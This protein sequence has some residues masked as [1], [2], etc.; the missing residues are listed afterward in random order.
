MSTILTG[1][2][3]SKT[4]VSISP[5]KQFVERNQRFTVNI[6][7]EPD[8][9]ISGAQFDF[10]FNNSLANIE[11]V[12][13]GDMLSQASAKTY[14]HKGTVDS[15]A[16]LI[17]HIFGSVLGNS[18][19]SSPGIFATINLTA[20]SNTG[21]AKFNLSNVIISGT[22][23]KLVSSITKNASVLIDTAP[24]LGLI[25]PKSVNEINS[26]N[27]KVNASD[28]DGNS[29]TFSASGLP[30]GAT[31]NR[32]TRVFTWVPSRGQTGSYTVTFKVSDG[33]LTDSEGVKITVKKLNNAPVIT[34]F[35]PANGSTFIKGQK[36]N[37]SLKAFD[38]D[39]QVLSYTIKIDGKVYTASS[40]YVWNTKYSKYGSHAIEV[41]VSDGTTKVKKIHTIYIKK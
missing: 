33:Y 41:I 35:T 14:F 19:V 16:G 10:L 13:E 20:G 12:K 4:V 28:A 36:I 2:A 37:I 7:I 5:E 30:A 8:A 24:V 21:V 1:A 23:S 22:N 11:S 17:K 34:S 26:L 40:S 6:S 39:K 15:N 3:S 25:G 31:F 18:R 9:P 32:S 29:L 38:A 27:F